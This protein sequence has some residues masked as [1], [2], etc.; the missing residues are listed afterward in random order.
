VANYSSRE[1]PKL[2]GR[3]SRELTALPGG[4]YD[5]EVVHRDE[6]VVIDSW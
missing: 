3:S 2:A 4:P 6:L 5:R 1:L